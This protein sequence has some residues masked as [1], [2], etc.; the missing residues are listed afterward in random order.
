MN[1]G[2]ALRRKLLVASAA[3][4]TAGT[5]MSIPI[6]ALAQSP[7][8]ATTTAGT[9]LAAAGQYY[10]IAPT[11][12]LDTRY[13]IGGV[14]GNIG[15]NQTVT[16]PVL[17]VGG[18]PIDGVSAVY[19][20]I[21]VL[22]ANSSGYIT[23]YSADLPDPGHAS[24]NFHASHEISGSDIIPLAPD[25]SLASD[26]VTSVAGDVNFTNHGSATITLAAQVEGYFMNTSGTLTDPTPGDTYVGLPWTTVCDTRTYGQ[27]CGNTNQTKLQ[28]GDSMQFNIGSNSLDQSVLSTANVSSSDIN[29]VEIEVGALLPGGE[30]YLNFT[31]LQGAPPLRSQSYEANEKSRLTDIIQ[32]DSSGNVTITNGG[33]YAVDIQINL[34]GV[35]VNPQTVDVAG[36]S[37]TQL[38][39]PT[40][41]CDTRSGCTN[42]PLTAIPATPLQPNTSITVR[43]L[44]NG[45]VPSTGVTDVADEID[46]IN[47]SATG[48]L[49]VAPAG[50]STSIAAVNFETG[51]GGQGANTFDNAVVVPTTPSGSITITN[52]SSGT[53]DV[54]VSARGYWMT[55]TAPDYPTN[56]L[57][58][59][60]YSTSM[61]TVV[62][63]PPNF[64]GGSPIT[65]YTVLDNGSVAATVSED[66]AEDINSVSFSGAGSDDISIYATNSVHAGPTTDAGTADEAQNPDST[67]ADATSAAIP[68]AQLPTIWSGKLVDSST[69]LAA[70]A[71][72]SAYAVGPSTSPGS[73]VG[74]EIPLAN[75]TTAAD[76]SFSL[77]ASPTSA[78]SN[79]MS[80][81]GTLRVFLDVSSGNSTAIYEEPMQIVSNASDLAPG[82]SLPPTYP[83]NE[84]LNPPARSIVNEASALQLGQQFVETGGFNQLSSDGTTAVSLNSSWTMSTGDESTGDSANFQPNGLALSQQNTISLTDSPVD[85][86]LSDN[87]TSLPQIGVQD[88][89]D[90][91]S[92]DQE[93]VSSG[94]VAQGSENCG[95][96]RVSTIEHKTT[97]EVQSFVTHALN[98]S[99]GAGSS[100]PEWGFQYDLANTISHETTLSYENENGVSFLNSTQA[101]EQSTGTSLDAGTST[102]PIYSN[103]ISSKNRPKWIDHHD[104]FEVQAVNGQFLLDNPANCFSYTQV[105]TNGWTLPDLT[106]IDGGQYLP[107]SNSSVSGN[108]RGLI[109]CAEYMWDNLYLPGPSGSQILK[110]T[111]FE[112]LWRHKSDYYACRQLPVY[113]Y[114]SGY[115]LSWQD[116]IGA[117]PT[118]V[119]ND[120]L[121]ADDIAVFA[122]GFGQVSGKSTDAAFP[123]PSGSGSCSAG[124]QVKDQQAF[125]YDAQ[126]SSSTESSVTVSI[127]NNIPISVGYGPFSVQPL[128]GLWTASSTNTNGNASGNQAQNNFQWLNPY[129]NDN[130]GEEWLCPTSPLIHGSLPVNTAQPIS[131]GAAAAASLGDYIGSWDVNGSWTSLTGP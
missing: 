125:Y 122:N 60:N 110:P 64:D 63:D 65:S 41:V 108:A 11:E 15:P 12:I 117:Y 39:A 104:Q 42:S 109:G 130:G 82:I 29:A 76:G 96:T 62:W 59:F 106:N 7:A 8:S 18:V 74:T 111:D 88:P 83:F 120:G 6:Q 57:T 37:Y 103:V 21:Q 30:G 45:S 54:I 105:H 28:P 2:L 73:E 20:N 71:E 48:W 93:V 55:P 32:P 114:H 100:P 128:G 118:Q 101:G 38:A 40:T 124:V 43:E 94:R 127:S 4:L 92:Y 113:Q 89:T 69:G 119:Q 47:N 50:S 84:G 91:S 78:L 67:T 85:A 126:Q 123:N 81:D 115:H 53:V 22:Y 9:T 87:M 129:R 27:G 13:G 90:L 3:A 36:S 116:N 10:P 52:V 68:A 49:T 121:P 33:G 98:Y 66:A 86:Q 25:G 26:G 75:G 35:F 79:Y 80:P 97:V 131:K 14:T 51:T 1:V 61:A 102:Q 19:V 99:T 16:V 44:G 58:S 23:D 34:E 112:I 70:A 17:G 107:G 72:V 24:V 95:Q 77:S 46:A 56:V 31:G 5:L